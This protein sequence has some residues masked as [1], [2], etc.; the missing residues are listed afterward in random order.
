MKSVK[1]FAIAAAFMM[2]MAAGVVVLSASEE[3]DA[4]VSNNYKVYYYNGTGWT[5]HLETAYNLYQAV[6][7]AQTSLSYTIEAD[8]NQTWEFNSNGVN[9]SPTYGTISKVNNSN[10]FTVFVYDDFTTPS[11]P[12]WKVA[13]PALGWYRCYTDYANNVYFPD[14]NWNPVV[15]AGAANVAIC[16]GTHTSIP[17]GTTGMIPLTTPATS[18]DYEYTFNIKDDTSTATV[19]QPKVV[20]YYDE[21]TEEWGTK[22][23]VTSD[24]SAGIKVKGYGSDV[25]MALINAIGSGNISTQSVTW[26][27]FDKGTP[28]TTDDYYQYYS[29]IDTLFN[30]TTLPPQYGSDA[31]GSYV[32]YT[33]WEFT[34]ANDWPAFSPGYLSIIPGAL[35]DNQG[36][37]ISYHYHASKW[38]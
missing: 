1:M 31:G 20:T 21:D 23:L 27:Y 30:V 3:S 33:Y 35:V 8:G 7:Q 25:F 38:Y 26:K 14:S 16:T 5:S 10:D 37:A 9:P 32:I 36:N 13:Q 24:L 11:S 4:A 2:V 29:W 12:V 22:T 28:E 6:N 15:S 19:S 17:S 18:S 34:T